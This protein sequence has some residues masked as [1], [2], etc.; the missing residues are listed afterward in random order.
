MYSDKRSTAEGKICRALA[1][2]FHP[3]GY[4]GF[5]SS[6]GLSKMLWFVRNFPEKVRNIAKW[7]HACDFLI[8]K[9]TDRWG[10]SDCTNALK[11]GYDVRDGY[12]PAYLYE[13]L[14]LKKEWFTEVVTSGTPIANISSQMAH[15]LGLSQSVIIVSGMTDGCAS[16]IASGAV[17]L[18]DW[19]TT[20]GTTLVVKG[21]TENEMKDPQERLY[22]HRHPGGYWMPGGAS[23]IG[24]DW[25]AR[26]FSEDLTSLNEKARDLI[27]TG[28]FAYP[29][30]QE[31]ERFP[32]IAPEARGFYPEGLSRAELFS[33]NMEGVAY[34]ERYCY[35]LI[36]NLSGE[37]VKAVYTAGGGSKSDIWLTIRS[38]VLNRP[39]YKMKNV[40]GAVGAAILAA[41]K[42]HFN[43]VI[44]AAESMTQVD[45]QMNPDKKLS[46]EYEKNYRKFLQLLIRKEYIKSQVHA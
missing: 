39:L 12:W 17:K 21:V 28:Q 11:S 25:I 2:K 27:P 36:E 31:G 26:E 33:A 22:N 24:A 4:T 30:Q 44:E 35:E 29:L 7:I 5:N 15:A 10:I 18:G 46:E 42:T 45:K 20:I 32:F 19:N 8:G 43:S 37:K 38:N 6:S 9:L 14:P 40:S 41:S 34:I 23:N 1:S 13:Q 3:G 16:Q